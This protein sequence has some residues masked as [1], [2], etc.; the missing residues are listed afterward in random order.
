MKYVIQKETGRVAKADLDNVLM[1]YPP[2]Y[3]IVLPNDEIEFWPCNSI[4][5]YADDL[6]D[7]VNRFIIKT[8]GNNYT[9]YTRL[10]FEKLSA[11]DLLA[12]VKSGRK[13]V[14]GASWSKKGLDYICQMNKKGDWT[15]YENNAE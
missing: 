8:G 7:L 4:F 15:F 13:Q 14:L 6:Y 5:K 11:K 10:Q 3:R 9:I 12:G 2:R 1:S